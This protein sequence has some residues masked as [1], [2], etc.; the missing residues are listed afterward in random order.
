MLEFCLTFPAGHVLH[1]DSRGGPTVIA[2]SHA[3]CFAT[4][5]NKRKC[6]LAQAKPVCLRCCASVILQPCHVV[7]LL[8]N[9]LEHNHSSLRI[10]WTTTF[11]TALSL[12]G[13]S[14][15]YAVLPSQ[16]ERVGI[17]ALQVG[18]LLS[19][20]RLARIPLNLPS[21]WLSDRFGY[22][23]PYA[24]G[25]LVGL[26]S[27]LGFGLF[28]GFYPLLLLRA[29]WGVAW[30]L[31]VVASYGLIF[32]ASTSRNR[33]RY[34]GIYVS[35]S[36]FGGAVG[37]MLGGF[38]VDALGIMP[39]MLFLASCGGVAF[40][41]SLTLPDARPKLPTQTSEAVV[42]RAGARFRN[43]LQEIRHLDRGLL[44]VVGLNF[45]HLLVVSGIFYSTFGLY[46]RVV[47]G[48]TISLGTIVLGVASLTGVLLFLRNLISLVINP[49]VG[50]LSDHLGNRGI[51]ILSAELA[52]VAGLALLAIGRSF[53]TTALGVLIFSCGFSSVPGL[54]L[55]WMGDL[56]GERRG[57]VVGTYQTMGDL[58]SGI[59]PIVAYPLVMFLG[60]RSVYGLAAAV[61]GLTAILCLNQQMFNR[62]KD[63]LTKCH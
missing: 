36:R 20:N 14:T 51:V 9:R 52:G 4:G 25:L 12:F 55:A 2:A 46:L 1:A 34:T 61:L 63:R 24:I 45:V 38:F 35:F 30:A 39:A 22:K 58:G 60:I 19:I 42:S 28:K 13:D 31:I 53:W 56:T 54:L 10:V 15:I 26:F 6:L 59:G 49:A 48:Q 43:V 33:G 5:D 40:L 44:I 8:E 18:W 16:Y 50:A 7:A 47:F 21:G 32:T 11:C 41:I 57:V 3:C 37:A 27:T 23:W 17:F 62:S 29:L